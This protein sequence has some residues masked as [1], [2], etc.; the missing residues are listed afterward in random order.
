MRLSDLKRSH[1]G[2]ISLTEVC[3]KTGVWREKVLKLIAMGKVH[4]IELYRVRMTY[5]LFS[6]EDVQKIIELKESYV[7]RDKY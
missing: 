1:P 6:P 4:P 5:Y 7:I 3:K 2:H